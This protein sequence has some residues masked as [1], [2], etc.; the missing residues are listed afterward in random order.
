MNDDKHEDIPDE[1]D[2]ART[3]F[4]RVTM[5]DVARAAGV[6]QSS[7]SLVLN[8][9]TGA[10]IS[11]VTR[12]RVIA[13]ARELGYMLPYF[14]RNLSH[15][16]GHTIAYLADE[17]STTVFP[18]QN[19]DGA[20]DAAWESGFLIST[21]ATRSNRELETAT[22]AAVRRNPELIGV[23]YAT[24]FTRR[25]ELPPALEGM[26]TVLLNCHADDP[27]AVSVVPGEVAGGFTATMYLIRHG[28]RS[29]GFING[30]PWMDATTE[31]LAGYRQALAS[32]DIAFDS[33]LVLDGD[34]LPES[35]YS[36]L[37]TLMARRHPPTA[38]FCGNDW[39]AAGAIEAARE[40]GLSVP[41][42]L[43][44]I[45]YDDQVVA[46]YT[47]PPLTTVVLPNYEMGRKAADLLID[48]VVHGKPPPAR[49]IKIDGQVIERASVAP[50]RN[51]RP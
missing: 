30:E 15:A 50:P 7:V 12:Q 3:A 49:L 19:I 10:R 1:N 44:L 34:W 23:I 31:R 32:V 11:E 42:D 29:I 22:I 33:E 51:A 36:G 27:A 26:P 20:R 6:S 16:P 48:G 25:I 5:M 40:L 41:E 17:L 28:H 21:H 38:I 24:I 9:M 35:G 2:A 14:R 4:R 46:S 45:G 43:S 18:V 37:K 39:M 8:G 13:A 47:R